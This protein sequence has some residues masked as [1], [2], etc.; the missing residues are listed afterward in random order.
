LIV[1]LRLLSK[2]PLFARRKCLIVVPNPLP[3]CASQVLDRGAQADAR[4]AAHVLDRGSQAVIR[5]A[6]RYALQVLH[7]GAQA[8]ARGAAQVLDRGAQAVA[9]SAAR[10]ASLV[11]ERGAQAVARGAVRSLS[12]VFDRYNLPFPAAPLL[13]VEGTWPWCSGRCPRRRDTATAR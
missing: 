3:R 11:L 13:C 9:R 2:V 4:C 7:R 1:A 8:D 6:T 5:S 12:Q 10:F